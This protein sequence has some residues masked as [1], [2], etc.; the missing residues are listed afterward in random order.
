M[1]RVASA[2][3]RAYPSRN[4]HLGMHV[5]MLE[6]AY[7]VGFPISFTSDGKATGT[8]VLAEYPQGCGARSDQILRLG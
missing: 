4:S 8:V 7:C 2:Y 1:E 3:T 5:Y 6:A